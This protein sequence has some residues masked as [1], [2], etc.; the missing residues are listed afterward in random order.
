[1][2]PITATLI[3][4]KAYITLS[5][6]FT[7]ISVNA[8]QIAVSDFGTNTFTLAVNSANFAASVPQ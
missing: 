6:D 5:G 7:T 3:P 2:C 1:V 8:S 4:Y